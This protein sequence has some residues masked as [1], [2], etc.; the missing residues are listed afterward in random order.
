VVI[1]GETLF[2]LARRYG[3]SVD[4]LRTANKLPDDNIRIGQRLVIPAR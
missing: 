3:V 4:N 2:G 1:Q